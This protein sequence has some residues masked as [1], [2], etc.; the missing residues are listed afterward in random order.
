MENHKVGMNSTT[1][2]ASKKVSKDLKS[3][4]F[5]TF[6]DLCLTK[7]KNNQI[8][9]CKIYHRFLNT[10]ILL[11]SERSSLSGKSY[12]VFAPKVAGIKVCSLDICGVSE[13]RSKFENPCS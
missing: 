12:G 11:L 6:L 5:W 1:R 10:T 9:H 2:K 4:K 13:T 7:F 8:L 3:L